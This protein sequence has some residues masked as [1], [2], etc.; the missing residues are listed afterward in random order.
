MVRSPPRRP[1]PRQPRPHL[2]RLRRANPR[3]RRSQQPGSQHPPRSAKENTHVRKTGVVLAIVAL[4]GLLIT[5]STY[6]VN[7]SDQ[8]ILLELGRPVQTDSSAG[9][10]V[11][12]P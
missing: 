8:V 2:Q 3:R 11:K 4:V 1:R 7:E 12:K 5:Q 10:Y 6:V 9:L